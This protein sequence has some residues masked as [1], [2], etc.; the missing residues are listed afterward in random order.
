MKLKGL[1]YLGL[2]DQFTDEE[3][4]VQHSVRD[5]VEREVL[6]IIETHHEQ[7]SFP[8]DLIKKF[9]EQG[10]L[11]CNLPEKYSC[12]GMSNLAYGLVCQELE[13]GDSGIRSC[14]LYTSPSPRDKR[15]SRMPSSA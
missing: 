7:A 3:L 5:F 2:S 4:M 13:R 11:G 15:Q 1:D 12:A 6:P 14:L 8:K 9:G 10:Y